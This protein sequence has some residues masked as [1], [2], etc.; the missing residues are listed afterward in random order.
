M[1]KVLKDIICRYKIMRGWC[2]IAHPTI[3]LRRM[4]PPSLLRARAHAQA[5]SET[6]SH[7][8]LRAQLVPLRS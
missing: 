4:P 1:N 3:A 2:T 5:H 7:L 6:Q 8:P